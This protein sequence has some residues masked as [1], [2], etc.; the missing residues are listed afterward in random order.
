M[1]LS[2]KKLFVS[3]ETRTSSARN[4]CTDNNTLNSSPEIIVENVTNI[5][6]IVQDDVNDVDVLLPDNINN[7]YSVILDFDTN[8][9]SEERVS[10]NSTCIVTENDGQEDEHDITSLFAEQEVSK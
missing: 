9:D 2:Q 8:N 10:G 3:K 1:D 4:I 5:S 6:E 7:D